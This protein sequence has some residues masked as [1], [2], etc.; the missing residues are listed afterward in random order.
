MEEGFDETRDELTFKI[1][2]KDFDMSPKML[3]FEVT[4]ESDVE[5][6]Y[7]MTVAYHD[8]E[9]LKIDNNLARSVLFTEP[10]P[11]VKYILFEDMVKQLL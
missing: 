10:E 6:F 3:L 5:F 7:N 9:K 11:G 2:V 1:Y 4:T 8:F